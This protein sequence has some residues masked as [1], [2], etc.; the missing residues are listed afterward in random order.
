MIDA[1]Q[2][3]ENSYFKS[4]DHIDKA[5]ALKRVKTTLAKLKINSF[6]SLAL[7]LK[8]QKCISDTLGLLDKAVEVHTKA[9]K[10]KKD[11]EKRKA[12][13]YAAALAIVMKSDF[14][15]LDSIKDKVPLIFSEEPD[16][17]T[18]IEK[19]WDVHYVLK[20]TFKDCLNSISYS[21]AHQPGDMHE[22]LGK[23]WAK[24]QENLPELYLKTARV[25]ERM[26]KLLAAG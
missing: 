12:E 5:S 8:E 20:N 14:A 16:M 1:K 26:Q 24:Y 10:L 18:N 6:D 15:K 2:L 23:T 3:I 11:I 19:A 7:D 22:A 21:I 17:L 4:K 9:A 13:R 25:V